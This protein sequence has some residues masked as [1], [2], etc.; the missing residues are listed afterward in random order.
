VQRTSTSEPP[1]GSAA[2]AFTFASLLLPILIPVALYFCHRARQEAL[3]NVDYYWPRRWTNRP[4]L[5]SC[6]V[7]LA[8]LALIVLAYLVSWALGM[9]IE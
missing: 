4:V 6:V 3:Q 2:R 7:W 8:V 1:S 5:L 9:K